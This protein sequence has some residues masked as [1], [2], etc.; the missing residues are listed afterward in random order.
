MNWVTLPGHVVAFTLKGRM[1][2]DGAVASTYDASMGSESAMINALANVRV[3]YN[4][5]QSANK[6][7]Y[8][9]LYLQ[10]ASQAATLLSGTAPAP[11]SA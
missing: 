9:A 1:I 3:A 7:Q 10:A 8:Q 5:L 11:S 4:G 2:V 6:Q